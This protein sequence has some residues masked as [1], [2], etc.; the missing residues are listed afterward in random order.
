MCFKEN[1]FFEIST[2]LLL[3]NGEKSDWL[4]YSFIQIKVI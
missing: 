3:K 4:K 1:I 2:I